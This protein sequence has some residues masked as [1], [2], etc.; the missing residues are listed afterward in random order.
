M[1]LKKMGKPGK[2]NSVV[3]VLG[4]LV[5]SDIRNCWVTKINELK[6][7][8]MGVWAYVDVDRFKNALL[9]CIPT[10]LSVLD[11]SEFLEIWLELKSLKAFFETG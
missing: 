6:I 4:S 1:S 3:W 11:I 5:L 10:L 9:E 7:I 2:E 8:N